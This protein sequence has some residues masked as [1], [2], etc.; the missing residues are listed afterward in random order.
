MGNQQ[1][2]RD[3]ARM[4]RWPWKFEDV[5]RE[6]FVH[7]DESCLYIAL[8]RAY[9]LPQPWTLPYSKS[10][11]GCRSWV[12]LPEEGLSLPAGATPA[13]S[14]AAWQESAARLHAILG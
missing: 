2:Y 11:G 5:V 14:E 6:R 10:Y 12:T 9:K 8:V 1:T 7:D 13:L 4:R 3:L